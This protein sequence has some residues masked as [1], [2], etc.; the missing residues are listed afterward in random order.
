LDFQLIETSGGYVP[1]QEAIE[2]FLIQ[3]IFRACQAES[4]GAGHA[5]EPPGCNGSIADGWADT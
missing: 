2:Q 5:G 1:I 4:N 3:L